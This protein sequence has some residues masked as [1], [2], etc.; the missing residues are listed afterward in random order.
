[1]VF[2]RFFK[3]DPAALAEKGE[4]CL[5][6]GDYSRAAQEF[7]AALEMA[8][9]EDAGPI[10]Q[11]CR[12][13]IDR[14]MNALAEMNLEE[15]RHH[16]RM[17]NSAKAA[18]H[19]ELARS[20]STDEALT[21]RIDTVQSASPAPANPQP[22]AAAKAHSCSGCGTHDH[23][24]GQQDEVM[25]DHFTGD[26]FEL[27]ADALPGDLPQRYRDMGEDFA[28]AYVLSD[29]ERFSE[30]LAILSAMPG[31]FDNDIVLYEMAVIYHR[32]GRIEECESLFRRVLSLNPL[33]PL[34][35]LAFF[36]LIADLGRYQEG[37]AHLEGMIARDV[38]TDQATFM[39]ADLK[40]AMGNEEEAVQLFASVLK[41]RLASEAAKRLVPLLQKQGREQEAKQLAKQYLKGCC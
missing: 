4:K 25:D 27:L 40:Q 13:G 31:A 32:Q 24:A 30:A 5:R 18:E 26:R 16:L 2:S 36:H 34:G 33:N 21:A 19:L 38:L 11:Q 35:N 14:A 20:Q 6:N 39:L 37:V 3:K 9:C 22:A 12:A 17:G 7:T 28:R 29:E 1:M 8:G 10:S 15:A 41:T 23:G